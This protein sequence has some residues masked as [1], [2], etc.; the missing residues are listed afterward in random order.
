MRE[1]LGWLIGSVVTAI[2][3]AIG[4][5]YES[6]VLSTLVGIIVGSGITYFVQTRTQKKSQER[7]WKREY[8]LE[9]TEKI[10]GPLFEEMDTLAQFLR[11]ENYE[12]LPTS[13][14]LTI[15]PTYHY[16][17]LDEEFRRKTER[18]YERVERFNR[19][20]VKIKKEVVDKIVKEE[21]RKFLKFKPKRLGVV[22][23]GIRF[24]EWTTR[25]IEVSLTLLKEKQPIEMVSELYPDMKKP[26]FELEIINP[27]GNRYSYSHPEWM[28]EF[29]KF[30][31]RSSKRLE[32]DSTMKSFREQEK[33]LIL[34][35][36]KA[37]EEL[38]TRIE[39]RWKV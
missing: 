38:K 23:K 1:N 19:T 36:G 32:A 37:K 4:W 30:W 22:V 17:I 11:M 18:F 16:L 8:T 2:A 29:D 31:K 9:I 13:K 24:N 5:I 7:A 33:E 25:K 21:A 14:W 26:S 28:V 15:K 10:Y 35:V 3:L 27:S 12:M 39:Q 20:L 34:E 6:G